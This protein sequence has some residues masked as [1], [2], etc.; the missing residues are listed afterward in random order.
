MSGWKGPRGRNVR[1][2]NLYRQWRCSTRRQTVLGEYDE[3]FSR[4]CH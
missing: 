4:R 1:I 2:A 3:Q